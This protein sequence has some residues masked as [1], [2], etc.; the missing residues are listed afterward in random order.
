MTRSR[1][2]HVSALILAAGES[3]R[4]GRLKQLLPWDG[5]TLIDWQVRQMFEA[6]AREVIVVLGHEAATIGAA[7]AGSPARIV[8]NH[9]YKEGRATSVRA[10]AGALADGTDAVLILSVDQPRPAWVARR[11]I[12]AWRESGAVVVI[13]AAGGRRGHPL[14]VDGS[15]TAE[16]RTVTE[17]ELG[18]RAITERH[19][20]DTLV[21]PVETPTARFDLNT[22]A[23]YDEALASF[24]R[25]DWSET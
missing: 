24:E 18:L 16:L 20:D 4:M 3:T 23:D 7:L 25:G 2:E 19:A 8:V 9:A 12:E 14:L 21:I 6:G 17:E 10:G 5:V 11:L 15:L 22:P 1:G 13:P